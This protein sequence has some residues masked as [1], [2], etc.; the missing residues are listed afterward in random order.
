[1]FL[2]F[3]AVTHLLE[4]ARRDQTRSL[5]A[6]EAFLAPYHPQ[7]SLSFHFVF[8]CDMDAYVCMIS[9]IISQRGCEYTRVSV[10]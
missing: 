5:A 8:S 9:P 6:A 7:H 1:M 2:S 4:A 3:A 10:R